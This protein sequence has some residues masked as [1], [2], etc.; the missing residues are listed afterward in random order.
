MISNFFLGRYYN[1]E[2]FHN[3]YYIF[4]GVINVSIGSNWM[5]RLLS[6][7]LSLCLANC[8][9]GLILFSKLLGRF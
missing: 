1:D 8:L 5:Q 9:V 2:K 6:F 3:F 7:A 4:K